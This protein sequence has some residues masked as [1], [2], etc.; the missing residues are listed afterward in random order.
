MLTYGTEADDDQ[1]QLPGDV[2][3]DGARAA[4]RRRHQQGR[5]R[6]LLRVLV[7]VHR[8][9]SPRGRGGGG[10]ICGVVVRR[11]VEPTEEGLQ[12]GTGQIGEQLGG[13]RATVE[14]DLT[15][16]Q[17][18]LGTV[19]KL[20]ANEAADSVLQMNEDVYEEWKERKERDK[21]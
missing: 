17:P 8:V 6:V 16:L 2:P 18:P 12:L 3:V 20:D 4:V 19:G 9:P 14:G 5:Q 10:G 21:G 15:E 13:H 7:V 1:R 11:R